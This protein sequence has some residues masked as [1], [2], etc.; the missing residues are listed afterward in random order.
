[1]ILSLKWVIVFLL[2]FLIFTRARVR[3][4]KNYIENTVSFSEEKCG[5]P[6]RGGS[7]NLVKFLNPNQEICVLYGIF[8]KTGV[9]SKLKEIALLSK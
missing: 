4:Y 2:F 7:E 1:L 9:I 5:A 8:G 3:K 6:E